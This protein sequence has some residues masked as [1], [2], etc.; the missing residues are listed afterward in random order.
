MRSKTIILWSIWLSQFVTCAVL[1]DAQDTSL[2]PRSVS[3]RCTQ[4]PK[5]V[6]P[7]SPGSCAGS[8]VSS[9]HLGLGVGYYAP[10]MSGR[11]IFGS[12]VPYGE[13]WIT[14][15]NA[16]PNFE[17]ATDIWIGDLKV[18][19][20]TYTLFTLPSPGGWKL[21]VN[22]QTGQWGSESKERQ[23]LGRVNMETAPA[24][25]NSVETFTIK[26]EPHTVKRVRSEDANLSH[27]QDLHFIWENTDVYVPISLQEPASHKGANLENTATPR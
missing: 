13:V 18:P 15:D 20:G 8:L 4:P 27:M 1:I 25:P 12:L 24:P 21:I 17:T 19:A 11:Q 22:K 6:V 3:V 10:S 2:A 14:G 5:G 7:E 16:A 26:F 9:G 23:D